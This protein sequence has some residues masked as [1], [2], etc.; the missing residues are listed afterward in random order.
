MLRP[1][2]IFIAVP[3]SH[4]GAIEAC[5]DTFLRTPAEIHLGPE[6]ILDRF[7]EAE[8]AKVGPIFALNLTRQP[9][10]LLER[11]E[12]RV[13][14]VAA[15]LA[16]LIWAAALAEAI[17]PVVARLSVAALRVCM[18]RRAATSAAITCPSSEILR[19]EAA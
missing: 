10:S 15:A 14:D 18:P 17:S 5:V 6:A 8:V 4:T 12:K 13:F 7:N 2:D 9:L 1:D 16:A 19:Q 3:W 11:F